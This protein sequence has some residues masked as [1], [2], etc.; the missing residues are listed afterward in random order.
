MKNI[1]YARQC[2]Y[3]ED[4]RAVTDA[5]NSDYITQGPKVAEFEDK[6]A[7]YCGAR[8]AVSVNSGT[9]ALHAA[10][11]AAG[12]SS[13]DEVI[14]PAI[15]FAASS[16]CVLYCG[17]IPKF[18][19]VLEDTITIDPA[20]AKKLITK[21]TKAIIPVDF[22]GHPAELDEI[23]K[24]AARNGLIVIEDAAHALGA[25][26]KGSK[27]GC[28]K[29][30]DMTILS[31][32][33]VKHIT[34]GE[35]GMVLTNRKDIYEKLVMFRNHGITRDKVKLINKNKPAWFYEMQFLGFNYRLTDIQCALGL[36]QMDK[37]NSFIKRRKEIVKFY[38]QEFDS[39][40][41][42]MCLNERGYAAS[43]WH[44]FPIQIM[45]AKRRDEIFNALR[46]KGIG[47]NLHYIPIYL[48]PYYK[49]LGY[50]NGLCPRA[51]KY[52]ERTITLPLYPQLSRG[53]LKRIVNATK[54]II[55]AL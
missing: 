42:V 16:N 44:I 38:K 9:S 28:G 6:V 51:E 13:K 50:K 8:Y 40:E 14:T 47:V 49:K 53:D 3:P 45:I 25:E 18:A 35:G 46:S 22:A 21:K 4:I 29:Y 33:A 2:I 41:K 23:K 19:D 27:V 52:Y 30:S 36:S 54:K 15:S 43:S 20:S 24:I 48:Q 26:Y 5:L 17:G 34:T 39:M 55:D 10:C 1:P 7:S 32:H 11:F 37:L 31:F 12:I